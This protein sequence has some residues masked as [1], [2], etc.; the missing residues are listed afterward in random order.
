MAGYPVSHIII[1]PTPLGVSGSE[2]AVSLPQYVVNEMKENFVNQKILIG[3]GNIFGLYS[4][5]DGL[6]KERGIDDLHNPINYGITKVWEWVGDK[7][8]Y[9]MKRD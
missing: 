4:C 1:D 8:V 5:G 2:W 6:I 3:P 9:L 7:K